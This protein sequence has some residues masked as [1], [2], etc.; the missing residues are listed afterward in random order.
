MRDAAVTFNGSGEENHIA[1]KRFLGRD[2][3]AHAVQALCTGV[4]D[5]PYAG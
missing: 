2:M 4:T 3:L 1:G 5:I